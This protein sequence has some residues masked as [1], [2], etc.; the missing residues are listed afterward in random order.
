MDIVAFVVA[1][2]F[3]SISPGSGAAVSVNNVIVNGFKG[4]SF[5]ILGLQAA[6]A[7]HLVLIYLGIGLLVSQSP[8][9][10]NL[11]KYL[12][13]AY[14]A[15]LGIEKILSSLRNQANFIKAGDKKSWL[16]LMR[17]GFTVNLTNPKS[18]IFLTAFL[19]QFIDIDSN[20]ATQYLLLGGIVVLVDTL[21]M[22]LYSLGASS[23]RQVLSN[24]QTIKNVNMV[25][26]VVFIAIA[27]SIAIQ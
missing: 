19:P 18:I 12:G 8:I 27:A 17:Q 1:C 25:F 23:F 11:I 22:F 24:E 10:Y 3:F 7:M 9:L 20:Q 14:L 6:L 26:G 4:A 16:T 2:I 15:F 21:V 5:G 13:I